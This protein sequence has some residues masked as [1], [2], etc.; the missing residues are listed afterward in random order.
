MSTI[1]RDLAVRAALARCSRSCEI[2]GASETS[3]ATV[4]MV[5]KMESW[6]EVETGEWGERGRSNNQRQVLSGKSKRKSKS[7]GQRRKIRSPL[8]PSASVWN[9]VSYYG[10]KSVIIT[11][12]RYRAVVD[13]DSSP[14][15]SLKPMLAS[16]F[17]D[18]SVWLL[19]GVAGG[20]H[21]GSTTTYIGT[22]EYHM[23]R[24]IT[25]FNGSFVVYLG[26]GFTSC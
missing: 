24:Q 6:G 3:G 12:W 25:R 11:Q 22:R 9:S 4:E 23:R 15:V 19:W 26:H 16:A 21:N 8:V 7:L 13:D 14:G 20:Q 2:I 17:L 1:L 18:F 5:G 10:Y